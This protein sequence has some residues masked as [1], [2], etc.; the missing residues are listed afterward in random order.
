MDLNFLKS[1]H[2]RDKG[3]NAKTGFGSG[4]FTQFIHVQSMDVHTNLTPNQIIFGIEHLHTEM[5][6]AL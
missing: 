5:H 2:K 6:N 4:S 1:S 3:Q